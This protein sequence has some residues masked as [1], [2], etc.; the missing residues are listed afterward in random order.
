M[1]KGSADAQ[2]G[3][4]RFVWRNWWPG[5]VDKTSSQLLIH[6]DYAASG[7]KRPCAVFE[8]LDGGFAVVPRM[9]RSP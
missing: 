8:N 7:R 5:F 6:S 1:R 2:R 3:A 9:V 4:E